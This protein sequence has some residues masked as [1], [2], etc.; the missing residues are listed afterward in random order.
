MFV[1]FFGVIIH[2]FSLLSVEAFTLDARVSL[3]TPAQVKLLDRRVLCIVIFYSEKE[4]CLGIFSF[5][6]LS[7]DS[8]TKTEFLSCPS[9]W[10]V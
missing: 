4:A 6:S 8:R 1:G 10:A 7:P 3:Y 2:L 9:L 5:L